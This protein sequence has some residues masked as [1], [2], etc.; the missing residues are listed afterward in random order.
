MIKQKHYYKKIVITVL[1]TLI[2]FVFLFPI[3]WNIVTAFKNPCEILAYPPKLIPS[4]WT[5]Y[6]F[7]KLLTASNGVF[8]QFF[9][10]TLI[11]TVS[12][13][14][15]V[16]IITIP[17]SFALA[18]L[19][20]KGS[21]IVFILILL[22]FMVP[23]QCLLVPLYTLLTKIHLY[24]TK[25][26]LILIYATFFMP[27]SI[28]MLRNAFLQLPQSLF[29]SAILDGANMWKI[30]TNL[31]LPLSIPSIVSCIIYLFIETWN[32]FILS[33]MFSSSNYVRNIQVGIM[34]FGKQ[35]FSSDWG[36]IN[37]GTLIAIIPTIVLF[38]ILQKYYIQ[39][40]VSGAVK[41]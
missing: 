27:F 2:I 20:F 12:T 7:N 34:N 24:N 35:R 1:F 29:E 18:K 17:C 3:Y 23:F 26:G 15:L 14:F 8:L 19:P 4:E 40:M 37:S 16:L 9:V 38:I 41:E 10:N 31:Y 32:D 6:Q 36:I 39:G 13:I 22:I 5:I 21:K 33:F 30:M 28:F 25:L 11:I